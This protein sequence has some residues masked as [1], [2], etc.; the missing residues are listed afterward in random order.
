MMT[1]VLR[2]SFFSS[3]HHFILRS[4]IIKEFPPWQSYRTDTSMA[5]QHYI[6][7]VM[8]HY[9]TAVAGHRIDEVM[10]PSTVER[11]KMAAGLGVE[12]KTVATPLVSFDKMV[13]PLLVEYDKKVVPLLFGYKMAA[14]LQM[15]V[16]LLFEYKMA[17]PLIVEDMKAEQSLTVVFVDDKI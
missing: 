11:G 13:V 5:L 15:V 9:L 1:I 16:P 6:D 17:A 14:C 10:R 2:P 4:P 7:V 3:A 12:Y 8:P